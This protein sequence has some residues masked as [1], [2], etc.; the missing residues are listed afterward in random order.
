MW[1]CLPT[2][3]YVSVFVWYIWGIYKP[4]VAEIKTFANKVAA[5]LG[6]RN[7]YLCK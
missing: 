1:Y 2:G 5:F 4:S 3:L 6:R 7:G